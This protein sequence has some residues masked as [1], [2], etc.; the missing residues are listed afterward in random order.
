VTMSSTTSRFLADKHGGFVGSP[1]LGDKLAFFT[2]KG[3]SVRL[4]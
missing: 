3:V 1:L 4:P 2:P